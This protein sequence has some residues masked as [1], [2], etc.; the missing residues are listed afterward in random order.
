MDA[1]ALLTGRGGLRFRGL[2][3]TTL[4]VL[5]ASLGDRAPLV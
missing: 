5:L 4:L 1:V 2:I 3:L